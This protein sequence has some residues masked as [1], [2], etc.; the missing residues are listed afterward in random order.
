M[1]QPINTL[2]RDG[3][4]VLMQFQVV[5]MKESVQVPLCKVGSSTNCLGFTQGAGTCPSYS[6]YR[7]CLITGYSSTLY[8]GFVFLLSVSHQFNFT[9]NSNWCIY[10]PTKYHH[11]NIFLFVTELG[12]AYSETGYLHRI[13]SEL[14]TCGHS[15][16]WPTHTS[17][18][19]SGSHE[20]DLFTHN[21][22]YQ[23]QS[24]DSQLY[25]A[26]EFI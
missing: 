2:S 1:S 24:T 16:I 8:Y 19:L 4:P 22:H 23:L 3:L 6:L 5:H 11:G 14:G 18:Q 9:Q 12:V 15:F 25:L 7:T 26:H 10:C 21:L 20:A 17:I 13:W